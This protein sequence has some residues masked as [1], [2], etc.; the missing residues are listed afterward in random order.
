MSAQSHFARRPGKPYES[1]KLTRYGKIREITASSGAS[2]P[3]RDTGGVR[4]TAG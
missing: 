3:R 4:S 2:H 1:P